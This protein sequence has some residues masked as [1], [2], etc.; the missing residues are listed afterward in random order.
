MKTIEQY[1]S[2][3]FIE[4]ISKT[5]PEISDVGVDISPTNNPKFGDYQTNIAMK[6]KGKL[7]VKNPREVAQK[8]HDQTKTEKPCE[9]ISKIE[10]AGPGFINIFLDDNWLCGRVINIIK[11]ERI[12]VPVINKGDNAVIDYSSP[13]IAK[14][15]HIGHLRSTVIGS[16]LYR[17][18]KFA[19]YNVIGDNHIGD[20]GT[21]FGKLIVAYNNWL[22][23]DNLNKDPVGELERLYVEFG[24]HA[25][26]DPQLEDQAR[27]ELVKLQKGDKDN[28]RLWK[29]FV[30]LSML[31]FNDIYERLNVKFDVVYG[32]SHYDYLLD[33]LVN[34]LKEQGIAERSEGA[35]VIFLDDYNLHPYLI[36]KSDGAFLYATTEIACLKYRIDKW[37]PAKIITVTDSRQETHFKQL[38]AVADKLGLD[39]VTDIIH[40]SFGRLTFGGE[41]MATRSGNVIKLKELLDEAKS[42]AKKIVDEASPHLPEEERDRIAETVG[43]S[44][45][46]YFDLS[47]NRTSDITFDWDS[48]LALQGNTATYLLYAYARIQSIFRKYEANT[49]NNRDF[50]YNHEL[51]FVNNDEA[52][53]VKF[54]LS[55]PRY[56]EIAV[57]SY[58]PNVICD[59]I[60]N[61]SQ[62]FSSF[63][64]KHRVLNAE[65][66]SPESRLLICDLVSKTLKKGLE[67]LSITPLD[68]M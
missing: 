41:I 54:A 39:K 32:E 66:T 63:Y 60:Y 12:G 29:K 47:Q 57:N 44:T 49:G 15:M 31:R 2:E 67:L 3:Y 34:D 25:E 13:N 28:R 33:D 30:E 1:L 6:L 51:K 24:R 23:E 14:T 4:I 53:L 42:R 61:L 48:A 46:K 64:N 45:I 17:I 55:F 50:I 38:K 43:T 10:I 16:A 37:K 8:I 36:Q 18:L 7:D 65:D 5:Y 58:K 11:D 22:D 20:W 52:K 40:V 59:F 26:N 27:Q 68:R 56:I 19:G 21:Q 35:Y 62:E 9:L